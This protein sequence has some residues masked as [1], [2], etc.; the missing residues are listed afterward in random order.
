VNNVRA[1]GF[2]TSACYACSDEKHRRMG[3]RSQMEID[4]RDGN[5]TLRRHS[6][7]EKSEHKIEQYRSM[8]QKSA[9]S[10]HNPL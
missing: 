5:L 7:C 9:I 10:A 1:F 2:G 4:Y 8:Y 6:F 3:P